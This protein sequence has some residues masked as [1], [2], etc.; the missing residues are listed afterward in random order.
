LV[1]QAINGGIFAV[2]KAGQDVG[3]GGRG[4]VTQNLRQVGRADFAG[5]ARAVGKG[6]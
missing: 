2:L 5:S 6:S 4:K 3:I 1:S